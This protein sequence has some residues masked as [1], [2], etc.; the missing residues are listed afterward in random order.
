MAKI[1]LQAEGGSAPLEV[2]F[3]P[4]RRS[5]PDRIVVRCGEL[6]GEARLVQLTDGTGWLELHGRVI[7]FSV[8]R[9]GSR[10]EVWLD[11][12][13]HV[14]SLADRAARRV[15]AEHRPLEQEELTAPMP[16]TILRIQVQPGEVFAAHQPLFIM[17]S[18]KME[19]TLSV[20]HAGQVESVLCAEGQLVEMGAVLAKLKP[21]P[22]QNAVES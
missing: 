22:A 18:M 9:T 3:E 4:L 15:G 1:L 6:Q 8:Q 17:E 10:I 11:G 12:R 2:E 14:L 5:E 13:I 21:L 20:P 16:G 7:P 19:M